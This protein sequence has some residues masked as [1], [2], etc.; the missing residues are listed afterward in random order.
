MSKVNDQCT[1]LTQGKL[2]PY[3]IWCINF[4]SKERDKYFEVM[5]CGYV[6][7]SYLICSHKFIFNTRQYIDLYLQ[8]PY[9]LGP[10]YIWKKLCHQAQHPVLPTRLSI[11]ICKRFQTVICQD[12]TREHQEKKRERIPQVLLSP[13]KTVSNSEYLQQ[14]SVWEVQWTTRSS[15]DFVRAMTLLEASCWYNSSISWEATVTLI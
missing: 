7:F 5:H 2:K 14:L 1:W 6:I 4:H 15:W 8:G 13:R 3:S 10:F 11:G 12:F 9:I